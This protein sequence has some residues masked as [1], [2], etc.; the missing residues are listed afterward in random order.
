MYSFDEIVE[1]VSMLNKT[2]NEE[3][4]L[5]IL[6]T[7]VPVSW[8]GIPAEAI[9]ELTEVLT[10]LSSLGDDEL[11][12]HMSQ[13]KLEAIVFDPSLRSTYKALLP[14]VLIADYLDVIEFPDRDAPKP[15]TDTYKL[16][17]IFG[18]LAPAH[19]Y[20]RHCFNNKKRMTDAGSFGMPLDN[21]D[22]STW[23][24]LAS[25]YFKKD[26]F[27]K[28]V[29]YAQAIGDFINEGP[30]LKQ[31]NIKTL[32][33]WLIDRENDK[34]I[35]EQQVKWE[36]EYDRAS[37]AL[38]EYSSPDNYIKVCIS[39]AQLKKRS[40]DKFKTLDPT[41][42]TDKL[43]TAQVKAERGAMKTLEPLKHKDKKD[44]IDC[45]CSQ[46]KKTLE[47][48]RANQFKQLTTRF[49]MPLALFRVE[50][51]WTL[52]KA[53]GYSKSLTY[54]D[55]SSILLPM[56]IGEDKFNRYLD[57]INGN[58]DNT[59]I[60]RSDEKLPRVLID[61]AKMGFD[62]YYITKLSPG[63][64][65]AAFLGYPTGCCQSIGSEGETCAIHGI[66]SDNSGF[67]VLCK[68]VPPSTIP[69]DTT[70]TISTK[71]IIGQCWAW[72]QDNTVVFDNIEVN[73]VHHATKQDKARTRALFMK[74]AQ[75]LAKDSK[76]IEKVTVGKG[77]GFSSNNPIGYRNEEKLVRLEDST[78]YSD[79]KVN[80]EIMYE[81]VYPIYNLSH[82]EPE[83]VLEYQKTKPE[84]FQ[85]HDLKFILTAMMANDKDC[86]QLFY[87]R[88]SAKQ[89]APVSEGEFDS[90][91]NT[92]LH[93]AVDVECIEMVKMILKDS[94]VDINAKNDDGDTAMHIA[95]ERKSH[96]ALFELLNNANIDPN[97]RGG[98][99]DAPL[100]RAV[101]REAKAILS[102]LLDNPKTDI[103]ASDDNGNTFLHLLTILDDKI[104]VELINSLLS[105][106]KWIDFNAT[107]K[108][109]QT[110]L[111][112]AAQAGK[113]EQVQFYINQPG[114]E[115]NAK[116]ATGDTAL[117]YAII[118]RKLVV[119][120]KLIKHSE[121][122]LYVANEKNE[123]PL[124]MVMQGGHP[125]AFNALIECKN[126]KIN[127]PGDGGNTLLHMAVKSR[128]IEFVLILIEKGAD[129]KVKNNKGLMPID[130]SSGQW[131]IEVGRLFKSA[132]N[133]PELGNAANPYG[134]F[135]TM[136]SRDSFFGL[137][138]DN[139]DP[140]SFGAEEE[141]QEESFDNPYA[142]MD[143]Y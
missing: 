90:G 71:S 113:S 12:M 94:I 35:R 133:E 65:K 49:N 10:E 25:K 104:G 138:I 1:V 124:L 16:A 20:L 18:D 142:A 129:T 24:Q 64:P 88:L 139:A 69:Q 130:L 28:A 120:D 122:D 4:I 72:R 96:L 134:F 77:M 121:I 37:A 47:G 95:V 45:Q 82:I 8:P 135:S 9:N 141:N 98:N 19:N 76:S 114:V 70:H 26:E 38:K 66:S 53:C 93:A 125:D 112:M 115:I 101:K 107:N 140:L 84:A 22:W 2:N 54:L 32:V 57:I 67:Y 111:H 86:A 119:I 128:N 30:E 123:T 23:R 78:V 110:P 55:A 103:K 48:G 80:Q 51:L 39:K 92:L 89:R 116:S 136:S 27:F 61:G 34:K 106:G 118:Q 99:G 15:Y 50:D 127:Q 137:G 7:K 81:R 33:S 63:D 5:N 68:G 41:K 102:T 91:G 79:A 62:G 85:G 46:Y 105:G 60:T 56:G 73:D 31:A 52:A 42:Q 13:E 132:G 131:K 29:P 44:Y 117:H 83:K 87:L 21:K 100:H 74:L 126:F 36:R 14:I 3:E 97:I 17:L 11:L 109:G 6:S 143:N 108:D 58:V 59:R 75:S 43:E 40:E